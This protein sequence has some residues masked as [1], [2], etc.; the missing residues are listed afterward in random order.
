[1]SVLRVPPHRPPARVDHPPEFFYFAAG[2]LHRLVRL[3]GGA[4]RAGRPVL[5]GTGSV[6]ESEALAAALE[7]LVAE[8]AALPER[9]AELPMEGESSLLCFLLM[10]YFLWGEGAAIL[11]WQGG[12]TPAF[13]PVRP[14]MLPPPPAQPGPPWPGDAAP[15]RVWREQ[16]EFERRAALLRPWRPRP[17]I[18]VLNARPESVRREAQLV[19]QAGLPRTVRGAGAAAAAAVLAVRGSLPGARLRL[20][21][22]LLAA[23]APDPAPAP[24]RRPR[25]RPPLQ[26]TIATSLAGRGTDILLG[27][28]PKGLTLQALGHQLLPLLAGGAPRPC[29]RRCHAACAPRPRQ[30]C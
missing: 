15:E 6:E 30:R 11:H 4:L 2:H 7:A 5:V 3:V 8:A 26:I 9:E 10:I 14:H 24:A 16:E 17:L 18:N 27:G 13:P 1:M 22:P 12:L 25:T 28:N 23:P 20:R 29:R 21:P 19:A